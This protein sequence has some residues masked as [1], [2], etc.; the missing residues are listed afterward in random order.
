MLLLK[1]SSKQEGRAKK[2]ERALMLPMKE[3]YQ[4][5]GKWRLR[6]NY[7]PSTKLFI[8]PGSPLSSGWNYFDD[9]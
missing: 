8:F 5:S 1:E 7:I 6:S 3:K 2:T 4:Q 9:V